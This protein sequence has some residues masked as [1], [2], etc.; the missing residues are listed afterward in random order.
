MVEACEWENNSQLATLL[1]ALKCAHIQGEKSVYVHCNGK[2]SILIFKLGRYG[3]D[4]RAFR[5]FRATAAAAHKSFEHST[6]T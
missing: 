1:S 3:D 2:R 6:P 4:A 5:I